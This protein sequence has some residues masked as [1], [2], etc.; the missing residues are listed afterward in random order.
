LGSDGN[1]GGIALF[2]DESL[3]VTLLGICNR[4]IDVQSQENP[5]DPPWRFSFIYG[6][7]RVEDRKQMWELLQRIK[8]RVPDP[9]I[10]MGDFN[11]VMW[12][13]EHFA[14]T[15]RGERQM[16]D[17]REVLEICDLHDIGFSGLPWTFDNRRGG[18]RN[19]KVR[20]DRAVASSLWSTHFP[21]A[22]IQH[23]VPPRTTTHCCYMFT[24]KSLL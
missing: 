11:E 15:R 8:D 16:E 20:L 7:P 3:S 4:L 1:S 22:A 18:S 12:Q 14:N 6:E 19:V 13:F 2:W 23:L 17:F 24:M 10:V 21:N 5:S 9:W